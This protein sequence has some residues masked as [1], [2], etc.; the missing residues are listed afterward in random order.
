[1]LHAQLVALALAATTLLASGCGGSSKTTSSTAA[2]TAPAT[3]ATPT[4]TATA[5]PIKFASGRPL[6]RAK[7]IA[8]GDAICAHTDRRLAAISVT[9][10]RELV[11]ALPQAAAYEKAEVRDLSKLVPPA[12]MAGDWAQIVNDLQI[13]AEDSIKIAQYAEVKNASAGVPLVHAQNNIHKQMAAV[14][15]RDGFKQCSRI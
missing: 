11:H 10:T 4:P 6:T 13:F 7:W 5:T 2:V 15:R 1:M 9:S 12:S 14:A 3:V 8:E